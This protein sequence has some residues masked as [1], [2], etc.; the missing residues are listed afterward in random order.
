MELHICDV[1]GKKIVA[2]SIDKSKTGIRFDHELA[3]GIYIVEIKTP[4]LTKKCKIIKTT[5]N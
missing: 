5:A 1:A 4:S 3:A 2:T